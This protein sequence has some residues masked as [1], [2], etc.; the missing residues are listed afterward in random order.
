AS[1]GVGHELDPFV[2]TYSSPSSGAHATPAGDSVLPSRPGGRPRPEVPGSVPISAASG[3]VPSP[4]SSDGSA[5]GLSDAPV[6]LDAVPDPGSD[7]PPTSDC[8][9]PDRV[10]AAVTPRPSVATRTRV[11]PP[12]RCIRLIVMPRSF[13]SPL[14]TAGRRRHAPARP[15]PSCVA[16]PAGLARAAEKTQVAGTRRAP[17]TWT[18]TGS[19]ARGL[20]A[21][22]LRR[23]VGGRLAQERTAVH[24][25]RVAV[26]E[27]VAR[28]LREL[29]RLVVRQRPV[30]GA[31]LRAGGQHPAERRGLLVPLG[32]GGEPRVELAPFA[33]ADG[34]DQPD[35]GRLGH[36]DRQLAV[37]EER[38]AV[39]SDP[40]GHAPR[41][42]LGAE[43]AHVVVRV[44]HHALA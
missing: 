27:E 18:S 5:L 22:L 11:V 8:A 35:A 10:S 26:V 41:V 43:D 17:A 9:H 7:D 3:S 39:L 21:E 15:Y 37:Q 23:G 38:R 24:R 2:T 6:S 13:H 25:E 42:Q 34:A 1:A 30:R 19:D 31:A 36:R 32:G 29:D 40:G 16:A 44:E 33:R 12:D 4:P 14:R 28:H 20:E